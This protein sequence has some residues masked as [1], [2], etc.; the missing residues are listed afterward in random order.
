MN[1]DWSKAPEW[2]NAVI[3]A[4]TGN[5]V[6]VPFADGICIGLMVEGGYPQ[7]VDMVPPH[8]WKLVE[9]RPTEPWNG[10]GLPPVGTVRDSNVEGTW[11]ESTVIA[12][13]RGMAIIR[14]FS[15]E[16]EATMYN[17]VDES[18]IRPIRTPEQIEAEERKA[19]IDAM[20]RVFHDSPGLAAQEGIA[21]LYD[22]GYRKQVDP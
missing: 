15:H 8:E 5:L 1:I 12:H 2:A 7:E 3:K 21:A 18:Q 10:E 22:A 11:E 4:K 16:H 9:V 13:D 19:A 14:R 6:W 20:Y 17:P